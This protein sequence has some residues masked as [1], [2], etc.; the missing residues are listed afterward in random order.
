MTMGMGNQ[1]NGGR[2]GRVARSG[3]NPLIRLIISRPWTIIGAWVLLTVG[4]LA[5]APNLTELAAEG[6]AHLVPDDS[7]SQIARK[8]VDRAWPDQAYQSVAVALLQRPGGLTPDDKTYVEKLAA[9]LE[10]PD[11]PAPLLRVL[12]PGSAPEIAQ[13]LTTKD[14]R[15]QILIAQ[16]ETSFVAPGQRRSRRG[17]QEAASRPD[18]SARPQNHLDGR[19]RLRQQTTWSTSRS[20]WI[21]RPWRPSSCS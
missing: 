20:R 17:A 3:G 19:R 12:G 6:Q 21:A 11:R 4:V 15:S 7:E 2:P 8:L 10:G 1:E 18:R 14:Q 9:R 5:T 13:Y 16:L